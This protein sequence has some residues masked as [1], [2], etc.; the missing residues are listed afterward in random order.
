[1]RRAPAG[2]ML[3]VLGA[4]AQTAPPQRPQAIQMLA[5]TAAGAPAEIGA[6]MLLRMVESNLIADRAWRAELLDQAFRMASGAK[7]P[8]R[9]AGVVGLALRTDS[10]VGMLTSA[11]EPG[12]DQLSLRCR[13]VTEMLASDPK[14]AR[15]LFDEIPRP[16][17]PALSCADAFTYRFGIYYVT[18]AAIFDKGFT[19]RERAEGNDTTFLEQ[20]IRSIASPLEL[21]SAVEILLKAKLAPDMFAQLLQ[22]YSGVL[23]QS[24]ADPRTLG[25]VTN[26]A[27]YQRIT[28]LEPV[29]A[30]NKAGMFPLIDA[31]RTYLVRYA[32]GPRC[33]EYISAP[34]G[35]GRVI[36]SLVGSFNGE[37]RK[38]AGAAGDAIPPISEDEMKPAKIEGKGK[39]YGYWEKPATKELLNDLKRLRFGL[40][41]EQEKAVSKRGPRPDQMAPYLDQA[42]R[43]TSEWEAEFRQ[44][45]ERLETWKKDH[46]ERDIDFF[47]QVSIAHYALTSLVPPGPLQVRAFESYFR[48]L[49]QSSVRID[50]PAQWFQHVS[51]LLRRRENREVILAEALRSGDAVIAAFTTLEN[52]IAARGEKGRK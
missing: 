9:I 34:K 14:R 39:A 44:F 23:K 6:H 12:L 5:D 15:E 28:E 3:F 11:L 47:H 24:T 49:A 7:H 8:M 48:H 26:Y 19:P 42:E 1:M 25:A 51:E 33:A 10:D 2:L 4:A 16:R 38:A 41:D 52:M 17:P 27:F 21:E 40:T 20:L 35:W 43:S 50:D 37:L 22:A 29:C 13:A 45:L 18:A 30:R 46:D 31:F 32:S 36:P